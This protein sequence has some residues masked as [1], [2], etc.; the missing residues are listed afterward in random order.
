MVDLPQRESK[1]RPGRRL[2]KV[3]HFFLSS[4]DRQTEADSLHQ[5]EA[6]PDDETAFCSPD[7]A[8]R[9]ARVEGAFSAR[10]F[11]RHLCLIC[12]SKSLFAQKPF[13]ACNLGIELA[14]RKFSVGLIET[15]TPPNTFSFLGSFFSELTSKQRGFPLM[16]RFP[17]LPT[18]YPLTL[19]DIPVDAH[20]SLKAVALEN[21]LESDDSHTL[22]NKLKKKFCKNILVKVLYSA[23]KKKT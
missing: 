22:L 3:S 23:L 7:N 11:E 1:R 19:V 14:R 18:P 10:T 8:S 4:Q 9:K 20:N 6:H 21:D 13:V 12:S 16:K 5:K 2:E 15:T 17:P